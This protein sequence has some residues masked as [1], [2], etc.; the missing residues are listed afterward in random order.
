[1]RCEWIFT[2][3]YPRD[4]EA[5]ALLW[6]LLCHRGWFCLFCHGFCLGFWCSGVWYRANLNSWSN[7][8]RSAPPAEATICVRTATSGLG[9]IRRQS[10]RILPS[11]LSWSTPFQAATGVIQCG[12]HLS[13]TLEYL[14]SKSSVKNPLFILNRK[15]EFTGTVVKKTWWVGC[16]MFPC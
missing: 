13:T 14:V 10:V 5:R 12:V 15:N 11:A 1:M 3:N 7:Q 4:L 9:V 6:I 16:R 8:T 2:H